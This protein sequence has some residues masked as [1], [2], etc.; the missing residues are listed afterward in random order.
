MARTID[1][2]YLFRGVFLFGILTLNKI[3]I[4]TE[5][6]PRRILYCSTA[7]SKFNTV[8]KFNK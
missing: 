2:D 4:V 7:K 8:S 3:E 1:F 6:I 5:S